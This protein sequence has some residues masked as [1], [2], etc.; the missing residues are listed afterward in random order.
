[1]KK[2]PA[3][4]AVSRFL[5]SN[6][7]FMRSESYS[8]SVRGYMKYTQGFEVR[9]GLGLPGQ[10]EHVCV[11]HV[12]GNFPLDPSAR[13]ELQR[14]YLNKYREHLQERYRVETNEDEEGDFDTLLVF[15]KS[16]ED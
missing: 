15:H 13:R 3:P 7:K 8:T 9:K 5:A 2:H 11:Y 4:Q 14:K 16:H 12:N 6:E 10:V 1:M